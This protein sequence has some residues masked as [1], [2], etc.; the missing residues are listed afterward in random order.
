[1]HCI[2]KSISAV[3]ILCS[4]RLLH[5]KNILYVEMY[6]NAR[7]MQWTRL[8]YGINNNTVIFI[9]KIISVSVI[10]KFAG[11]MFLFNLSAWPNG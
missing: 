3:L 9:L 11:V 1:M 8:I 5:V 10:N 7:F 2:Y 4:N 6:I